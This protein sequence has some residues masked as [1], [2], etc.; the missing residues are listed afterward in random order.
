MI[1]LFTKLLKNRKKIKT[2][3]K[4][5]LF[6]AEFYLES[7]PDVKKNYQGSALKHYLFRGEREGRKPNIFFD[8]KW[9]M[10]SNPDIKN[11]SA[12]LHYIQFGE[13]EGRK[14]SSIFDPVWYSKENKKLSGV[15]SFDSLEHYLKTGFKNG[16]LPSSNFCEEPDNL[17]TV[18]LPENFNQK[19]AVVF[20]A[21][22]LEMV[23]EILDYISNIPVDFGLFISTPKSNKKELEKILLGKGIKQFELAVT[24][25]GYDIFPFV[26]LLK[27]LKIRDYSLICK[28]HTKKGDKPLGD[29]WYKIL[30]NSILG[31]RQSVVN[32]LHTFSVDNHIGMI[33]SADVYKSAQRL[34]Y[35]N[36]DFIE[37]II[38]ASN[39]GIDPKQ[40]WGFF[41]GSVF[42][43]RLSVFETLIDNS[44]IDEVLL[45]DFHNQKTGCASSSFH[46]MER[47]FGVLPQ[48]SRMKIALSYS[49]NIQKTL[50]TIST[51][52][53]NYHYPSVYGINITLKQAQK[54]DNKLQKAYKN[55][56]DKF[57]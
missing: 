44:E 45:N 41:A 30:F 25:I 8:P 43:A 5:N 40:E 36:E 4:S 53:N 9:Y 10:N 35:G 56:C 6:D 47:F 14:P 33:G 42:W 26:Q 12:L 50:N 31:S 46:A 23:P 51:I 20:H 16:L 28:V 17:N 11:E 3:R 48:I 57:E 1:K 34:M 18:T 38:D 2:I 27:K 15:T 29:Y 32:I 22:Y 49:V 54:K 19:I 37:Q 39:I 24:E 21:Y 7:Y 52:T 13:K 55:R